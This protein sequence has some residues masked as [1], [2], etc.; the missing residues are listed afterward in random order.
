MAGVIK[1]DAM[2]R[3]ER[4][5]LVQAISGNGQQPVAAKPEEGEG[6]WEYYIPWYV[7]PMQVGVYIFAYLMLGAGWLITHL[8]VGLTWLGREAKNAVRNID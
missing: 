8:G 7:R 6:K 2:T 4:E 3:A 5:R 1:V